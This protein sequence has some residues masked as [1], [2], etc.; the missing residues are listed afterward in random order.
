MSCS[1]VLRG[2]TVQGEVGGSSVAFA[3]VTAGRRQQE[4]LSFPQVLPVSA[5]L[6]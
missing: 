1:C 5:E 3:A 2:L 4:T 6:P